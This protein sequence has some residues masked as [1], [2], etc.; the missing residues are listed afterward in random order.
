MAAFDT[1]LTT[2]LTSSKPNLQR[3]SHTPTSSSSRK[4]APKSEPKSTIQAQFPP[5]QQPIGTTSSVLSADTKQ[6]LIDSTP[7]QI[8]RALGQAE[9]LVRGLNTVLGLLTWSSGQDWLSFFLVVGW[10]VLCLYGG[11]I[12]KFAGNFVPVIAI[13]VWYLLQKHGTHSHLFGFGLGLMGCPDETPPERTSTHAS[14]TATL[15]EI[16]I[17]RTRI[18]MFLT[19]PSL[20]LPHLA[21]PTS[22]PLLIRLCLAWPVWLLITHKIIPPNKITLA[23]GTSVLCWSAPWARVICIALWRSRTVRKYSGLI[24]GQDLMAEIQ[25]PN[26]VTRE[27]HTTTTASEGGERKRGHQPS[28]STSSIRDVLGA[29]VRVTQT[30]HQSQRRWIGVGWTS[31]LFPNERSPWSLPPPVSKPLAIC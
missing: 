2:L 20:L 3:S 15:K 31:N 26:T 21:L 7:P 10:W 1:P 5:G 16:D 18:A 14:L 13:A 30:L 4:M 12:V 11:I 29:G 28:A 22:Q 25:Q 6:N 19:P 9:P 8:V 27:P 23:F 17:L 24:I